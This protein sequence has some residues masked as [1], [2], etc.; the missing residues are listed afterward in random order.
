MSITIQIEDPILARICALEARRC[1]FHQDKKPD[2][3]LTDLD[4]FSPPSTERGALTIG[5]S[6]HPDQL[7]ALQKGSVSAILSLPFSVREFEE[8]LYRFRQNEIPTTVFAQDGRLWI[9]GK[10]IS[11]SQKELALFELLYRNKERVVSE[12]E[13][14]AILD[15]P[16]AKNNTVAVYLYRLRRK[17]S[18]VG[19]RLRTVR[20]V[21]CQWVEETR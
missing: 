14:Q 15:D 2:L 19:I 18:P 5:L 20:K 4:H 3:V 21:G 11:L 13:M 1:G 8:I 7:S 6:A 9:N 10:R 12:A 17:L 16:T